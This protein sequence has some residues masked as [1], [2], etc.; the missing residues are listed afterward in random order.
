[1]WLS[2]GLTVSAFVELVSLTQCGTAGPGIECQSIVDIEPMQ[3]LT[4]MA[5]LHALGLCDMKPAIWA[6]D[7]LGL[8]WHISWEPPLAAAAVRRSCFIA[9]EYL[10]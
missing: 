4:A 2:N 1:M 8:L 3:S 10:G 9:H 7:G 6:T 5:K